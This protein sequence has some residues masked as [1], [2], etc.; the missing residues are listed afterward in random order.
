M[1]KY[2]KPKLF[3]FNCFYEEQ[4]YSTTKL[5]KS[6]TSIHSKNKTTKLANLVASLIAYIDSKTNYQ[7]QLLH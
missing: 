7:I 2:T 3:K 6:A 4:K 1:Q 5:L